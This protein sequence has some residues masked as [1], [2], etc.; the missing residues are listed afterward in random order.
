MGSKQKPK[1]QYYWLSNKR[2]RSIR[3]HELGHGQLSLW[4]DVTDEGINKVLLEEMIRERD[5]FFNSPLAK[6]TRE[7]EKFLKYMSAKLNDLYEFSESHDEVAQEFRPVPPL[8]AKFLLHLLLEKKDKEAVIGDLVEDYGKLQQE[9]GHRRA[10]IWFYKQVASFIYPL[11]R[12][13][14][15]KVGGLIVIGEW[16]RKLTH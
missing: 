1:K 6:D 8:N 13:F 14:V 7:L 16:L 12:R 5:E 15:A 2:S 4:L 10:N 3:A 11:L 9:F